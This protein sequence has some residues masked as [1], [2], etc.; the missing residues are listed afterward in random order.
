MNRSHI[1][2]NYLFKQLFVS[3]GQVSVKLWVIAD[4]LEKPVLLASMSLLVSLIDFYNQI[5]NLLK[6][7]DRIS[8]WKPKR[9]GERAQL[10]LSGDWWKEELRPLKGHE[11]L[12]IVQSFVPCTLI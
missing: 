2:I 8:V 6:I 1:R 12:V 5:L 4:R 7:G 9:E 11:G 10:N 3:T